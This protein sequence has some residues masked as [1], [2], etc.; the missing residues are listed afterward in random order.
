[1]KNIYNLHILNIPVN[2]NYLHN[3]IIKPNIIQ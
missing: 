2:R 1:M 3:F